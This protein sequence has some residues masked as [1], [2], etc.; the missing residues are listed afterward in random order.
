N[1]GMSLGGWVPLAPGQKPLEDYVIL[2]MHAAALALPDVTMSRGT[3]PVPVGRPYISGQEGGGTVI[4]ATPSRQHLLGKRVVAVTVQRW[5]SLAETAVG[6]GMIFEVPPEMTDEAAA[7]YLIASHTAFHV[8]IRRGGIRAGESAV[9][10][11][12]GGGLGGAIL[13]LCVARGARVIAV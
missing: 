6:V 7:A 4:A 9:V 3:Y 2:R 1:M 8:A 13:Q 11:G 5:G 10:L 12:A